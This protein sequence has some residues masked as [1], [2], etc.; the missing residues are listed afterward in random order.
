MGVKKRH[1]SQSLFPLLYFSIDRMPRSTAK[2]TLLRSQLCPLDRNI[3]FDLAMAGNIFHISTPIGKA[4]QSPAQMEGDLHDRS[5]G[6][7]GLFFF[8]AKN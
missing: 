8:F 2:F 6:P 5:W 4:F 3:Y 7:N 1:H